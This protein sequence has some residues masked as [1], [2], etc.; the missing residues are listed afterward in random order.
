MSCMVKRNIHESFSKPGCESLTLT[1]R[2]GCAIEP[3]SEEP[4]EAATGRDALPLCGVC[5]LYIDYLQ[6]F[7]SRPPM[8]EMVHFREL[9]SVLLAFGF[10]PYPFSAPNIIRMLSLLATSSTGFQLAGERFPRL[11]AALSLDLMSDAP[12]SHVCSIRQGAHGAAA[13]GSADEH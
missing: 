1:C 5:W 6:A 2:D 7:A 10:L 12:S 9:S 4:T 3:R 13:L 8:N 11:S